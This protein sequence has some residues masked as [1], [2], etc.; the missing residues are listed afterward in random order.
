MRRKGSNFI[1][2]LIPILYTNA[3]FYFAIKYI[4]LVP[5]NARMFK[6]FF[7]QHLLG[8]F[9]ST[10][11]TC[12]QL[13]SGQ[14][15]NHSWQ[16]AF[17]TISVHLITDVWNTDV[18]LCSGFLLPQHNAMKTTTKVSARELDSL[19][20]LGKQGLHSLLL[21][22]QGSRA[23]RVGQVTH[24][25][26]PSLSL[27]KNIWEKFVTDDVQPEEHRTGHTISSCTWLSEGYPWCEHKSE[28]PRHPGLF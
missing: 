9:D 11:H 7:F 21:L 24:S 12:P 1:L 10:G 8:R 6:G 25:V 5:W 19:Q 17:G 18:K 3:T 13:A 22:F 20:C 4:L 14:W 2:N 27:N 15:Y 23:V 26:R 28:D 16:L